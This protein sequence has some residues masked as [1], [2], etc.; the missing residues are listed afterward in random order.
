MAS[1]LPSRPR[2]R[3]RPRYGLVVFAGACLMLYGNAQNST[4]SPGPIAA[5]VG[6]AVV[7][8]V[9]ALVVVGTMR[10]RQRDR[11]ADRRTGVSEL[12]CTTC[13]KRLPGRHRARTPRTAFARAVRRHDDEAHRP[14][15]P[16][17]L[18]ILAVRIALVQAGTVEVRARGPAIQARRLRV[19]AG[20]TAHRARRRATH[21][22]SRSGVRFAVR[23]D[24]THGNEKPPTRS[25]LSPAISP[26]HRFSTTTRSELVAAT[27]VRRPR[28]SPHD[29]HRRHRARRR[30]AAAA[31]LHPDDRRRRRRARRRPTRPA[32]STAAPRS[33]SSRACT[34]AR[35]RSARSATIPTSPVRGVMLDVSRDKVPTMDD[36]CTR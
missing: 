33:R 21:A 34:T 28:G 8:T 10:R 6:A 15:D 35:C 25:S 7:A 3:G 24:L 16:T 12:S 14:H 1:A 11:A 27:E 20:L 36:A 17:I 5:K 9:T 18:Q 22:S 31:G 2:P 13:N 26:A 19:E 29:E 4:V 30:L 32:A 23:L